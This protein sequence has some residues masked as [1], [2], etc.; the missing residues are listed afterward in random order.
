M[1]ALRML[2]PLLFVGFIQAGGS[3][4]DAD[5]L[6]GSWDLQEI[7]VE[8]KPFPE[9]ATGV[10]LTGV[11]FIFAKNTLTIVPPTQPSVS[12]PKQTLRFTVHPQTKPKSIDTTNLDG[13]EKGRTIA[14][15]YRIEGD[16]LTLCIPTARGMGRPQDF[17]AKERSK[18]AVF[19]L[20][21]AKS[22]RPPESLKPEPNHRMDQSGRC[23]RS[24]AMDDHYRPPGH[25]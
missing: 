15:I 13:T 12:W 16:T 19:T 18:L 7:V 21:R 25:P 10:K 17:E 14:G 4:E 2:V 3:N 5:E 23:L 11:K 20:H 1:T 6:Q 22:S 8:G 9:H 24:S